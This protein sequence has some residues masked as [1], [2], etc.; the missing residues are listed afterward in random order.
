M[1]LEALVTSVTSGVAAIST[2]MMTPAPSASLAHRSWPCTATV[3]Y[4]LASSYILLTKPVVRPVTDSEVASCDSTA[5]TTGA[6]GVPAASASAKPSSFSISSAA[7][8]AAFWLLVEAVATMEP[9]GASGT[10]ESKP[11][12]GMPL[13]AHCSSWVKTDSVDRAARHRASGSLTSSLLRASTCSWMSDSEGG[14]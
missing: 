12:T 7:R 5:M 9:S 3:L 8:A 6:S 10:P 4:S 2:W 13:A 11:T 14:P 1:A